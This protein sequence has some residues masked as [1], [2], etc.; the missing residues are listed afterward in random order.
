M[1]ICMGMENM[2]YHCWD[3][4]WNI[5]S[6]MDSTGMPGIDTRYGEV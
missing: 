5:V 2:G 1:G 4:Q 3:E 6:E